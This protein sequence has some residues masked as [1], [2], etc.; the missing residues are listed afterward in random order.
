MKRH[1]NATLWIL[2]GCVTLARFI[3]GGAAAG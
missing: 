3:P 2:L 1:M